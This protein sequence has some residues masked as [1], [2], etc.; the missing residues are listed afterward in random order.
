VTTICKPPKSPA[1]RAALMKLAQG[2]A[3]EKD[4]QRTCTEFL[5]LDGWRAI[6]TD[7]PQLRGLGVSEKGIPDRLYIRYDPG[8]KVS[9]SIEDR[10]GTKFT[11]THGMGIC[12]AQVLWIEWK[13]KDG[14]VKPHQAVWN[15]TERARGALA[16]IAGRDFPKTIEGFQAWYRASGLMRRK[17]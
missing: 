12:G 11:S 17:I 15:D 10:A 6:V 4:I 7:P 14:R 2:L 8:A 5:E 16:L 13:S 9:Y 3:S 1:T